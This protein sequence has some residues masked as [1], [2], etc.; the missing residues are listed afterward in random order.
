MSPGPTRSIEVASSCPWFVVS[1]PSSYARPDVDSRIDGQIRGQPG[2][3]KRAL[4][5]DLERL[6]WGHGEPPARTASVGP[7]LGS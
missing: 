2:R 4:L 1:F 5:R 6:I 3:L 7:S